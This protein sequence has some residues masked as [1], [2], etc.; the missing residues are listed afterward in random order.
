MNFSSANIPAVFLVITAA[1]ALCRRQRSQAHGFAAGVGAVSPVKRQIKDAIP[2]LL[3]IIRN[4]WEGC[5][6]IALNGIVK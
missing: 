4:R 5:D 2:P 3:Q 1:L 6:G